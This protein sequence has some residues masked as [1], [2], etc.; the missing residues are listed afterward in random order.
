VKRIASVKRRENEL[1]QSLPMLAMLMVVI[2]LFIGL[3]IDFGFAYVTK[4][5]LSKAVDAAC[6]TGIR[7]L[8]Q[9]RTQAVAVARSSFDVNYGVSGRD[10]TAPV[11]SIVFSTDA[12][13]NTL[14]TVDA[15][16]NINTFFI[17][18]LPQY[19]TL[20]V[21]AH[22]QATRSKLVMTWAL[23]RSNSMN[24]NGGKHALQNA[25]PD[26]ITAFDPVNDH[27]AMASFESYDHVDV[28]MQ[29][30]FVDP[31]T[32]AVNNMKFEGGT[33]AY[34]GLADAQTQNNSVIVASGENVV[35]VVIFFTDG[36]ANMVQDNLSCQPV[37]KTYNY[38]GYDSGGL[39]GFFNPTNGN[40]D[41]TT[42][43]AS[44]VSCCPGVNKFL[45]QEDG[46][47]YPFNRNQVTKEAEY[48]MLALAS[49]MR[50]NGTVI[51]TI[52][53]GTAINEAFLQ[54]LAND[55]ASSTFDPN[56]PQ[57]MARF[58]PDCPSA[59]CDQ[60]LHD[61][62]QTIVSSILLRLTE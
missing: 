33:F 57:G 11:V 61:V 19:T 7:N 62:V 16:A 59:V 58:A 41:C 44:G 9:G 5:S 24:S 52:G 39:V 60:E 13:D 4:A 23:D 22:A 10:N 35:K 50:S 6:L 3:A 26:Y 56:L 29:T 1:G 38:G 27:M 40:E 28:P 49:S 17:R 18:I 55:P 53:L 14:L 31:I 47:Y 20:N 46:K 25:V 2:I 21:A 12:N 34:G 36:N 48:R 30:D 8:A 32:T 45:S 51:Y 54:Q 42:N 37:A 43:G 15:T